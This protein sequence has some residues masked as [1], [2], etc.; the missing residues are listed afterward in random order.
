MEINL[1]NF[2]NLLKK[3]TLN[4]TIDSVQL[5]FN[6]DTVVS[7]MVTPARNAVTIL[8]IKNDVLLGLTDG[9]IVTFNFS[10]P[11]VNLIPFLNLLTDDVVTVNVS[12]NKMVF[13]QDKLKSNVHFCSP[14]VVS[15]FD[16]DGPKQTFEYFHEFKIDAE[17]MSAFSKIKKIANKFGKIY[18]T[19]EDNK[20]YIETGDKTN[21]A[22]NNVRFELADIVSMNLFLLFEYKNIVNLLAIL[23]IDNY[24]EYTMKFAYIEDQ[25][26][27]MLYVEKV[28]M[29]EKYYLMSKL[30]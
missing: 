14:I 25:K 11:N 21:S 17:F 10:E 18:F 3:A 28:D 29:S 8:N 22:E 9:D 20:F 4:N 7:K 2:K 6:N 19:V 26:L 13:K 24:E 27:G 16:G 15:T 30:D 1:Y 5:V 12:D 23:D